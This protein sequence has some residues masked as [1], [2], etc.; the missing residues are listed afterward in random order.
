MKKSMKAGH[1]RTL[2]LFIGLI[3]MIFSLATIP[4]VSARPFRM[5]KIPDRGA[6]FG[7][8]T[9]HFNPRGGGARN[10]FGMDYEKIGLRAGDQYTEELGSTDS[11]GDKQSNDQEFK[12]GTHPGDPDSRSAK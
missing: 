3:C 8:G 5:G 12:A 4:K 2:I 10:P 7:C 6:T 9:C 11:D 1:G